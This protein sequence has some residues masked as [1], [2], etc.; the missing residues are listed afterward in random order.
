M[1]PALQPLLDQHRTRTAA[2]EPAGG[3]HLIQ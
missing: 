1:A 3:A 2:T